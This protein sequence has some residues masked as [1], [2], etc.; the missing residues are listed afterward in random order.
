MKNE[1]LE[2]T[3]DGKDNKLCY[4]KEVYGNVHNNYT[5]PIASQ[6]GCRTCNGYNKQ[7]NAYIRRN[8]YEK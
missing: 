7:C 2:K 3:L 5:G 6:Y 1:K 4:W 8:H